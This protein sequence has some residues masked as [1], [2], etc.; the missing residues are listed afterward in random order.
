[1]ILQVNHHGSWRNVDEFDPLM[2]KVMQERTVVA[3][4]RAGA[5]VTWRIIEARS[6]SPKVL[7]R[8]EGPS[9]Q[10]RQVKW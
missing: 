4:L 1:V 2:L 9:F 7:F 10:W 6:K 5:R 8:L 3:A